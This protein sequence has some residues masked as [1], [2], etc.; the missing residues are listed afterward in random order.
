MYKGRVNL[1]ILIRAYV[2]PQTLTDATTVAFDVSL[3]VN[4]SLTIAGD[5]T[6]GA[7]S[8]LNPGDS[9]NIAITQGAGGN[10]TLAYNAVWKFPGGSA[11]TLSTS[12]G[13]IDLLS[14]Y[15]PD[16]TNVFAVL[17]NAFA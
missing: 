15:S 14:W 9:G 6:L 7:P 12:A 13:D 10:H 4:A 8:N 3:G 11:P 2:L 16:G 17:N 1:S 5:R